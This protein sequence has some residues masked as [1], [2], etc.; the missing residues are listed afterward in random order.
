V[1]SISKNIK[2]KDTYAHKY[3]DSLAKELKKMDSKAKNLKIEN[4]LYLDAINGYDDIIN[5]EGV[6]DAYLKAETKDTTK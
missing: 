5:T 3:E 4:D 6:I 1:Q 2:S